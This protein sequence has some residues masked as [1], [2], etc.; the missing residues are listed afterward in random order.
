MWIQWFR[1]VPRRRHDC[2]CGHRGISTDAAA[3]FGRAMCP[4]RLQDQAP[5]QVSRPQERR[6]PQEELE[7]RGPVELRVLPEPEANAGVCGN[8]ER[9]VSTP[10]QLA[11][12]P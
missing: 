12:G 3:G 9:F 5:D 2:A 7:Q 4:A 11:R 8:T 6:L 10:V 1:R